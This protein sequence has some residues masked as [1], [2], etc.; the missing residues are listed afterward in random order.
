MQ[1]RALTDPDELLAE[2]GENWRTDQ[3]CWPRR[4]GEH[5]E[6]GAKAEDPRTAPHVIG[7]FNRAFDIHSAIIEFDLPY[8][9]TNNPDRYTYKFGSTN[10]GARVYDDGLKMH[11]DHDTDPASGQNSA[12]HLVR[13]HKFKNEV[14][15]E[16]DNTPIKDRP[17]FRQ[18]I[19]FAE[20]FPEVQVELQA[21]ALKEL[22]D[23]G[24]PPP[25]EAGNRK[26]TNVSGKTDAPIVVSL[27][28]VTPR[29]LE[30]VWPGV[31][32]RGKLTLFA[33]DPGRGKSL[34]GLDIAARISR[35]TA[36][37]CSTDPAPHGNVVI[38]SAEDSIDDT[39]VPRLM[40]ADADLSRIKVLR[41]IRKPDGSE[42]G[43]SLDKHWEMIEEAIREHEATLFL[44]DPVSAFLGKTDSN[45]NS[46]VR[47]VLA[48]GARIAETTRCAFA[49]IHHLNKGS[50]QK[51]VYRISGSLAF[52]AA[53]RAAF[54]V[55]DDPTDP[56]QRL[57]LPV[58][59]NLGPD[60]AGYRF[61]VQP[62]A[63]FIEDEATEVPVIAWSNERPTERADEV[64]N[65]NEEAA[66][67]ALKKLF[68][69]DEQVPKAKV[70]EVLMPF[71]LSDRKRLSLFQELRIRG[72]PRGFGGAY[73]Y[74]KMESPVPV[75]E[76][77]WNAQGEE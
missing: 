56:A 77:E 23:L 19:D 14:S 22:E 27:D 9:P 67:K 25:G 4:A 28:L 38:C 41:G 36:W 71:R 61:Q 24:P 64:L 32:W 8:E 63:V 49:F 10:G 34:I 35:G 46:E 51:A 12:F 40:A 65:P 31:L 52:S 44:L 18:M 66:R 58:K 21:E 29:K 55:Q 57:V 16:D 6:K 5:I 76:S 37:P 73:V 59:V 53:A 62:K 70:H 39:I 13:I 2:L 42:I 45:N 20:N 74:E 47:G 11:S 43:V 30:P 50:G 75:P 15:L 72:R 3:S 17:S 69:S 60:A 54:L 68:A 7:A 26:S 1:N 33:G 48:A